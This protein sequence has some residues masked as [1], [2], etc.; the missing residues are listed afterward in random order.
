VRALEDLPDLVAGVERAGLTIDLDLRED[1]TTLPSSVSHAG[2]R[3]L[4]EGLTNVLRHSTASRATIRI[5]R[6]G[7]VLVLEVID[8]GRAN[9]DVVAEGHGLRGM[10]DR[11]ADLGGICDA[12][13]SED[14]GWR[15]V[16]RLPA[17]SSS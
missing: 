5:S 13:P 9:A 17:P 6:D 4:Q 16:A 8:N 15:V 12:G 14:C 3:I 7:E 11:A 10:Q 1:L 2:Y